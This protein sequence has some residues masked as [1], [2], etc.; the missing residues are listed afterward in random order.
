M[1]VSGIFL[2][3]ITWVHTNISEEY[4]A[5]IFRVQRIRG[6]NGDSFTQ[7]NQ[8]KENT[9]QHTD[10]NN[11]RDKDEREKKKVSMSIKHSIFNLLRC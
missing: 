1:V 7:Y 8:W 5:S 4:I 3:V 10:F 2:H 11:E 9:K 6:K